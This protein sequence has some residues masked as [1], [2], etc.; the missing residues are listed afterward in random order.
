M[1]G[2]TQHIYGVIIIDPEGNR[3]SVTLDFYTYNIGL[4]ARWTF[5]TGRTRPYVY[6]VLNNA[7]GVVNREDK[8]YFG[9]DGSTYGGGLGLSY[10]ISHHFTVALDGVASFGSAKWERLPF[11]NSTGR[12]FDP[13]MIGLMLNF[14]FLW[15]S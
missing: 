13:S 7:D 4:E 5:L 14:S 6:V 3:D 10:R 1:Y 9:Y 8:R 2:Y 12:E 11:V 15:G